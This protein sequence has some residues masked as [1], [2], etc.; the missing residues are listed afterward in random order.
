MSFIGNSWDESL[1][2]AFKSP[3]Y[4]NLRA[5]LENEYKTQTVFPPAE[6]IFNAFKA[7]PPE[8]V[9]VVILGQ[10]PYHNAGEA[11]GM[12]F[13]VREGVRIPPS[14]RNIFKE[15][16]AEL[17]LL[18]PATGNLTKWGSQGVLLL[19]TVLTVRENAP[20]S[21]KNKGWEKI[22][23]EAIRAL[24]NPH[25][26]IVFLLW[27]RNARE[28]KA[29]ITNATHLVLESA[30]PSPLSASRGFFGCNHFIKANE[31][32]VKNGLAPIN[33]RG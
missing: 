33:W 19:N 12:A 13:S 6:D 17:G 26:P 7:T 22:T 28:K 4:K 2:D 32:L 9:R 30:H 23:D 11:H 16:N 3:E 14:L 10:D 25:L 15:I 24:N 20:N 29:L 18:M 8:K 31:F 5:F 27:G 1:A 21:H